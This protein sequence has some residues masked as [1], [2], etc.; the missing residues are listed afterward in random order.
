M[1]SEMSMRGIGLNYIV[2]LKRNYICGIDKY[3]ENI[4]KRLRGEVDCVRYYF[5]S[6]QYGLS[7]LLKQFIFFPIKIWQL[8][9]YRRI[10]FFVD[11]VSALNFIFPIRKKMIVVYDLNNER[12]GKPR[13]KLGY[14][15]TEFSW[16]FLRK[17]DLIITISNSTKNLLIKKLK[18]KKE[19]IKIVYP[20]M[21][22]NIYRPIRVDRRH[23]FEKYNIQTNFKIILYVGSDQNRK[24]VD[25][26]IKALN[27]L[28]QKITDFF[29]LKIGKSQNES[30]RK[31]NLGLVRKLGLKGRVKFIEHVEEND[32]P[33]FYNI[34]EVFVF[35]SIYEGFGMPPLEAMACGC[36]V[37]TTDRTSLKE[38]VGEAGIILDSVKPMEIAENIEK[39]FENKKLRTDLIK[40]GLKQA[41]KFDW[42]KSSREM[43][44]ILKNFEE[45]TK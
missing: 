38:V 5:K 22:H 45:K 37:I 27:L 40:K 33:K 14:W 11:T 44:S 9:R 6:S 2:G 39:V 34:A 30:N 21:D 41:K 29:F 1:F 10:N 31:N 20:A 19:K 35:P 24:N 15:L 7:R 12:E 18:I 32:L 36:P 42:N 28:N 43:Y 23:L 26:I 4:L 3:N 16:K 13:Q 8:N 25:K 17:A